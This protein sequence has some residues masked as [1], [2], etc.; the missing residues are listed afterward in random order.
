M[1][2]K[3]SAAPSLTRQ[4][5]LCEL[6]FCRRKI[7]SLLPRFA[8]CF[9]GANTEGLHYPAERENIE[10]TTSFFSGM[11]WLLYQHTGDDAYLPT[12]ERHLESFY[13]RVERPGNIHTHDLGFLYSLSCYPAI[14][15]KKNERART[16]FLKAADYLKARYFDKA[17]IIQA[18]GDLSDPENRGRMIIDCLLNLPLLYQ[19]ARLTGNEHYRDIAYTH[20]RQ[21]QRYLVREDSSTYHTFYMDV[22]TGA[23]RF[24]TT[25]QG[26]SDSSC[27]A[28]G[29]VW[30]VYGFTLSYRHTGDRSFLDTACR[31]L[32]YYLACLPT[33]YVNYWDLCF[34]EG[35][36]PRDSSSTAIVCCGILELLEH[37]PLTHPRRT[38]YENAL[39]LMMTSL[40]KSY[41]TRDIPDADGLLLHGVYS[42]PHHR[43]VDECTI[44]GDY[45]YVEA[46]YRLVYGDCAYWT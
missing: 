4:F 14:L 5:A 44:W 26:Y 34:S 43:G 9:P 45:Y 36:Q 31:L 11:L 42:I 2:T 33:D 39:T 15:L 16:C 20:A 41:T 32:D 17:G 19:A 37:L 30:G 13:D 18:W 22:V 1:D 46:L 10:W 8:D 3:F 23:P 25:A 29:Q 7:S 27:W 24:G 35:N 38:V 28:R 6:D 40:A 12:L 21:A